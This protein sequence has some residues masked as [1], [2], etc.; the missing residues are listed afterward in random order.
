M[1]SIIV[2]GCI[3][4]GY[5]GVSETNGSQGKGDCPLKE[6]RNLVPVK[7]LAPDSTIGELTEGPDPFTQEKPY[8]P[9]WDKLPILL[10]NPRSVLILLPLLTSM[11]SHWPLLLPR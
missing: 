1:L 11:L 8:A 6:G 3:D 10:K 4:S 5:E 9:T 2:E 7:N